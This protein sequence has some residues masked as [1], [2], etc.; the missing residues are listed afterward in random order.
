MIGLVL[1]LALMADDPSSVDLTVHRTEAPG[2]NAIDAY[3]FGCSL[4]R[5]AAAKR[6]R[7]EREQVGALMADGK[8]DDAAKVALRAADFDLAAKVRSLCT[9][10]APTPPPN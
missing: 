2:C 5:A 8:C 4:A 9:P 10:T 6:Q 7:Q 1:A 3:Y